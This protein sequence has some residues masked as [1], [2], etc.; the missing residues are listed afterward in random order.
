MGA[1]NE[2]AASHSWVALV[3]LFIVA[4]GTGGIK[5]NVVTFGPTSLM[6]SVCFRLIC[7]IGAD[8][9]S[10]VEEKKATTMKQ[11]FFNWFYFSINFGSLLSFTGS[12]S[13]TCESLL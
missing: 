9:F 4:L 6:H 11:S 2:V 3:S 8:Q 12:M 13:L 7:S 5:A 1:I 10:D